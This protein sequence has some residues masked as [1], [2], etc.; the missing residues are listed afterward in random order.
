MNAA[1]IARD[2]TLKMIETNLLQL[3]TYGTKG[4]EEA[5]E[6][7]AKQVADFFNYIRSNIKE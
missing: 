4:Q 2:I 5:N 3:D 6:F 7:N 1:E